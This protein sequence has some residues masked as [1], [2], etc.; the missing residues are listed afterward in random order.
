[1]TAPI[2]QPPRAPSIVRPVLGLLAG[3]GITVLVVI[4]GTF[5]LIMLMGVAGGIP[6]RDL[7]H[8]TSYLVA[9]LTLILLA[10][11]AGGYVVSRA[12]AGQSAFAVVLL[13]LILLVSGLASARKDPTPQGRPEW[14]A[15]LIPVAGAVGV[16]L[17]ALAAR[18]RHARGEPA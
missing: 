6:I 8:A 3:L 16:G 11:A 14:H 10:G 9:N 2:A 17:G 7:M 1:M 13:A 5:L 15:W 12:T 4:A 18:R